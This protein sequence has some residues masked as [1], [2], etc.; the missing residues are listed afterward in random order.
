MYQ[1]TQLT[2]DLSCQRWCKILNSVCICDYVDDFLSEG[3]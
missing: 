1:G 2:I 3:K